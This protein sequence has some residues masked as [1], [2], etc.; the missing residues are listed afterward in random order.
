MALDGLLLHK[1]EKELSELVPMK[2]NK[3][4]QVSEHEV[5][6][7]I[8]SKNQNYKL[9]IS[10]HSQYNR[11]NLT[12]EDY[13]SPINANNFSMILRKYIDGG[14][15]VSIKQVGLDRL[16]DLEIVAYDDL[17]DRHVYHLYVELMGKYAN[18]VLVE[19][20][21][22]ID[23][24]KR[25]P[26]FE[27]NVRTIFPGSEFTYPNVFE[28]KDPFTEDEFDE[29]ESLS[30]Q[31]HGFSPLLSREFIYRIKN[32][33]TFKDIIKELEES[34]SLYVYENENQFHCIELKHLKSSYST[35]PLMRGFDVIYYHKQ[36][37]ER[38]REQS[39]DLY[40]VV[41]KELTKNTSKLKK[42][43]DTL[44]EAMDCEKYRVYGDL[45]YAYSYQYPSKMESVELQDFETNEFIKIPLDV[46]YD[47]KY[48]AKK[49]YQ[50][51][52]KSKTAQIEVAKQIDLCE[53]EIEY[54]QILQSQL[55]FASFE[56]AKEIRSEL[57][58][59]GYLRAQKNQR[60]NNKKN[61][62]PHFVTLNYKDAIIYI[63][64]NNI[65]NDFLTFHYARKD[66]L[67]FHAQAYHGAH[68]IAHADEINEDIIRTC[69][70]L[71]SYYSQGKNSSSVPV[72]YT[73]IRNLRKAKG[74]AIGQALMQTYKTIYID[75]DEK[76]V[77]DLLDTYKK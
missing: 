59:N 65:Q 66:D 5:L 53:K 23:A 51:Y 43:N 76:T 7:H 62:L 16:L 67:W 19:N 44:E 13:Q 20:N 26:P 33:E 50:K 17:T 6:F 47:L 42:L 75:P 29:N 35:Y 64:K 58:K 39:G 34:N 30:K 2:I 14:H 22:I 25:I 32:K 38:I 15:I 11:I 9:M 46:K 70:M 28:K 61:Q 74:K 1:L 37:K 24:L 4:T 73:Q 45:L 57:E 41:K 52:K 54:F 48:N 31:F 3:C 71:A 72:D 12:S 18:I 10:T 56:D 36:E 77:V 60:K 55:D 21:R 68:V 8:R 69:A 40:K 63:G 49:Y 27:N